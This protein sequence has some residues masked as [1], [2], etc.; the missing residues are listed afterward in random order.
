[1]KKTIYPI[2]V[3]T[4][5]LVAACGGG[6]GSGSGGTITPASTTS[7]ATPTPTPTSMN[8][9]AVS[10]S[11][12]RSNLARYIFLGAGQQLFG[13]LTTS[14]Q[15][16][17]GAMTTLNSNVLSGITSVQQISGNANVA[18]GRWAM[19]TVT[20]TSGAETLTSQNSAAYQYVAYNNVATFP[21][22]GAAS[23]D[24]GQFTAINY[25]GGTSGTANLGTSTG[26]G[27]GNAAIA[28]GPGG[29]TVSGTFNGSA[30][31]AIGS[32]NI[33]TTLAS[34]TSLGITGSFLSNGPGAAI[35]IGTDG[36]NAYVVVAGYGVML[37]NGAR[38][39]GVATFHC[40]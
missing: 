25:V 16:A 7:P 28:F 3:L 21:T 33:G 37:T 35:G 27:T 39:Q 24:A 34:T 5:C 20:K 1:M 22:S 8:S 13:S 26:T 14:F 6:G 4:A 15:D 30:G 40:K 38:Y 9:G 31:G 19:G 23:C 18:Q 17:T 12:V 29:A 32:I 2:A 36:T 11:Y 10:A